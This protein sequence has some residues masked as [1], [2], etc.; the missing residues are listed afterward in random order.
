MAGKKKTQD[1]E[2]FDDEQRLDRFLRGQPEP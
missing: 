2:M 1:E